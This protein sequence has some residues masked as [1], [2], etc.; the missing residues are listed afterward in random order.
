MDY[1]IDYGTLRVI[2]WV[3]LGVLL[4]G[5]AIMDGFDLGTATVLPFV[6]TDDEERRI[7]VNTIGP[8][9]EGNQVWLVLGAGSIFAA[10][11]PLYATAFS[12]F[13]FAMMLALLALILRPVGFKFRGKVADPRWRSAWDWALF[14]SGV[15]PTF[16]FG[17]AVG[18]ALL[19]V[20]FRFDE[21]HL[22]IYSGGIRELLHPFAFASGCLAVALFVMQG[23]A[24]LTMKTV[25]PIAARTRLTGRVAAG[26]VA[27]LFLFCGLLVATVLDGYQLTAGGD[28]DGPSN[29][30]NKQVS[31][32]SGAWILGSGHLLAAIPP[33]IG[34]F[35][36]ILTAILI[37]T[38]R[39]RLTFFVSSVT[40]A[41]VVA[42]PGVT[43]FPF[44][45]PS[46]THPGSSITVW[47]ASS[48]QHT[49]FLMLV[50]TIIFLPIILAY[51]T[52]VHRVLAG[53]ITPERLHNTENAY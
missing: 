31:V 47:D 16:I 32:A 37:G 17:V 10:W 35:G 11:P 13:Y 9:W 43:M 26:V 5:F 36:A 18:N 20:P 45:L 19:G 15:V 29:P 33:L 49:L 48:S 40:V 24:W 34:V 46:S 14:T 2:W 41:G 27:V 53:K 28:P 30:F 7:L 39:E 23:C 38:R 4:I 22:P 3:L 50:A 8:F 42:T 44:I 52:W 12:G 51:T 1:L 6:G 21:T 25:D